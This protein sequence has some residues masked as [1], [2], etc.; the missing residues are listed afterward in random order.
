M[1]LKVISPNAGINADLTVWDPKTGFWVTDYADA[2]GDNGGGVFLGANFFGS[3][4]GA[5]DLV[6]VE[7]RFDAAHPQKAH[8]YYRDPSANYIYQDYV[9]V[10]FSVWDVTSTPERQLNVAWA[11]RS[12]VLGVWD[13][14]SAANGGR[15]YTFILNSTYSETPNAFYMAHDIS[16]EGDQFDVLYDLWPNLVAGH[17]NNESVGKLTITPYFINAPKD[18]FSFSTANFKQTQSLTFQKQDID[19]IMAVPNPYFGTDEY[20]QNQFGR[21]IRFTN[22]P[23]QCKIRVFNLQGSLIRTL[24]KDNPNTTSDWDLLNENGL[25]IASGMYIVYLDM[26][27]IGTKVLKVAVIMAQ[28]RLDNF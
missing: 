14:T 21:I 28:E 7:L 27:G 26:P 19:K 18:T 10:P 2:G 20:E 11:D 25:P 17:T 12:G 4:L 22:L 23:A 15:E 13:P 8:R 1:L 5:A 9:D 3:T 16:N 6:K 24:D